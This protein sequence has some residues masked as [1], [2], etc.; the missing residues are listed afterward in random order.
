MPRQPGETLLFSVRHPPAHASSVS[1]DEG[2]V[3]YGKPYSMKILLFWQF[4]CCDYMTKARL[5]LCDLRESRK[6]ASLFCSSRK[7]IFFHIN[8]LTS[9]LL[10][11]VFCFTAYAPVLVV[12]LF[13]HVLRSGVLYMSFCLVA[14]SLLQ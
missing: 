14:V 13:S 6:K 3:W 1:P 2:I 12:L 4:W 5:S 8:Q 9:L 11:T 10:Y 7:T